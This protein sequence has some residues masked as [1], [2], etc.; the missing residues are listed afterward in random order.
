MRKLPQVP[1]RVFE[2]SEERNEPKN[3]QSA[4]WKGENTGRAVGAAARTQLP[5]ALAAGR[6]G[7]I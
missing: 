1:G 7:R 6:S 3:E 5:V 2:C 4:Q